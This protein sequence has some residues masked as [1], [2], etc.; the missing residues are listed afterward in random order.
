MSLMEWHIASLPEAIGTIM[1]VGSKCERHNPILFWVWKMRG[2]R[3]RCSQWP[4]KGP[5]SL[6]IYADNSSKEPFSNP[7]L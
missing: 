5:S 3:E 1:I 6:F 4:A 2:E 7:Q